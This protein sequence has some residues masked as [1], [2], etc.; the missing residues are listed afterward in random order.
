MRKY[1]SYTL[2]IIISLSIFTTCKQRVINPKLNKPL[3]QAIQ[4]GNFDRVVKLVNQGADFNAN[5]NG[6]LP[7]VEAAMKRSNK[8]AEYLI[9]QGANVNLKDKDGDTALL[10]AALKGNLKI[11]K[12]L[13]KKG[14]KIKVTNKKGSTPLLY[15]AYSG[16]AKIAEIL[17]E[18]GADVLV[19]NKNGTEVI[20]MCIKRRNARVLELVMKYGAPVMFK[21]RKLT[22]DLYGIKNLPK[23]FLSLK[24]LNKIKKYGIGTQYPKLDRLLTNPYCIIKNVSYKNNSRIIKTVVCKNKFYKADI[25]NNGIMKIYNLKNNAFIKAFG[26]IRLKRY[27]K[28]SNGKKY[29]NYKTF[30]THYKDLFVE[31]K[32]GFS[33]DM[34]GIYLKFKNNQSKVPYTISSSYYGVD[35]IFLNFKKGIYTKIP[36][37]EIIFSKTKKYY[38]TT[39]FQTVA[40]LTNYYIYTAKTHKK[41]KIEKHRLQKLFAQKY[42]SIPYS[43]YKFTFLKND[44]YLLYDLTEAG[45]IYGAGTRFKMLI[46]LEIKKVVSIKEVP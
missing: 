19:K 7:L 44:R 43:G 26:N 15:A 12:L 28:Y 45:A 34:L 20:S 29:Y 38:I 41:L 46:D 30:F 17:L 40:G 24:Y 21:H 23:T 1:F 13:L 16:N 2:I 14:A 39:I 42:K 31:T 37:S 11:F 5:I 4:K 33:T 9:K 36:A 27:E 25:Y 6:F 8:I 35:R 22:F 10:A 32:T 3:L 18:K